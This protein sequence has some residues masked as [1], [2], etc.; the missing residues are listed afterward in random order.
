MRKFLLGAVAALACCL[1]LPAQSAN[2]APALPSL[3]KGTLVELP[4]T[5]DAHD[6]ALIISG[7]GG[8]ADL[9]KQLGAV[10]AGRGVSVLGWD[11]Y[12]YFD[13]TRSPEETAADIAA[14]LRHYQA[15]WGKDRLILIGFSFGGAVM[16]FILNRLP[17]DLRPK[18]VLVTLLATETYANWEIHWGDWLKDSPHASA[19]PLGPEM[20]RLSGYKLLC[21]YGA[22]EAAG[23]ICPTLQ[24]VQA[25]LLKL[26]GGHHFDGNYPA[27]AE[28]ILRRVPQ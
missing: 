1:A 10:L 6:L 16:P 24:P 28:Q 9:D 23:S 18:V 5:G 20:A 4:A 3:P 19:R 11:A 14:T 2:P 25:E 26:P 21:V 7:D 17:A 13:H 22:D 15:D 27:L 12:K 8:W